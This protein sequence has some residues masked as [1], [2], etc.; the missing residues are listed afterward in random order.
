MLRPDKGHICQK[1][2]MR[3]HKNR[4]KVGFSKNLGVKDSRKSDSCKNSNINH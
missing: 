1:R 3:F 2:Y 4:L